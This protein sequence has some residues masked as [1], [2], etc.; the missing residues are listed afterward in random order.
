MEARIGIE[1]GDA[2]N[3]GRGS[4]GIMGNELRGYQVG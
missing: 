2:I 3:R 4:G 1:R